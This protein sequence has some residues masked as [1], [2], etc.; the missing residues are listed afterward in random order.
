[1]NLGPIDH[2]QAQ[3][4]T[5]RP[6]LDT[7]SIAV[8]GRIDRLSK[9]AQAEGKKLLE[10]LGTSPWEY[11]VL[12][13]LRRAAPDFELAPRQL[14]EALLVSAGALTNR[15]DHL[16]RAQLVERHPDPTDRRALRVRLTPRGRAR[17]DELVDAYLRRERALL[18]GLNARERRSLE[19]LLRKLLMTVEPVVTA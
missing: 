14:S 8:F 19:G 12:V 4:Q 10:S 16:E 13:T 11:E 1:M 6:E 2:V 3:W 9:L 15:L 18:D 5:A 7:R 17:A